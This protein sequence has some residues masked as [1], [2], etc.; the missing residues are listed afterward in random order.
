MGEGTSRP[1]AIRYVAAPLYLLSGARVLCAIV[2]AAAIAIS[3]TAVAE[4]SGGAAETGSEEADARE[5]TA[6]GDL[7]EKLRRLQAKYKET[8]DAEYLFERVLTL[9][10]MGEHA[11]ALEV[12]REN[13][14]SFVSNEDV[15]GVSVV[16]QR[17]IDAADADES[18]AANETGGAS[19]P[20]DRGRSDS[21]GTD[22]LGIALTGV[23]AA[24][25][26]GG[27]V[28]LVVT[29]GR[30]KELRCSPS[31]EGPNADGCDGVDP[32][33][34]DSKSE[35]DDAERSVRNRRIVGWS[36]SVVGAGLA[37]YGVYRLVWGGS[38]DGGGASAKSATDGPRF[39]AAANPKGAA[40]RLSI[41]F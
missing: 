27:I 12:L 40:L 2:V 19:E 14:E 39:S 32:A 6:E 15:E 22:V 13:R 17:L 29:N 16:E 30:A 41:D 26:T 5:E 36:L 23:G 9:E 20:T 25:L 31:A 34:F 7:E 18:R 38:A 3:G 37:G 24:A 8:G 28:Q 1:T 10:K 33:R 4:E 11:F 21:G 35:F